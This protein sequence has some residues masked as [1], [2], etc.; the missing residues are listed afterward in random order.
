MREHSGNVTAVARAMG[1]AR[2][3]IQRWMKR[4]AIDARSFR[5]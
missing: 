4:Y 1:K 2:M 3:Q 5:R